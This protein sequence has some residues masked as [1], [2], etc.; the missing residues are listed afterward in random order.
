MT[1][2]NL[3]GPDAVLDFWRGLGPGG[4]FRKDDAVD[5]EISER[6][7]GLWQAARRGELAHWTRDAEGALA[8]ILV[9]DQFPRNMFRQSAR[10]FSTDAAAR[11]VAR[12]MLE[13]GHDRR[14]REDLRPFCYMPFMHS[15]AL[16]DQDLCVDLVRNRLD[17]PN[18]LHHAIQHRDVIARFGR[19][20]HRNA[21]LGRAPTEAETEFLASGG[22]V[23]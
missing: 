21:V 5:A 8:L 2:G 10:A 11:A 4:W 13:A 12:L 3:P 22:Y 7:E 15:E 16:E 9:L 20:P 19:F 23:P 14:I 17:N 18:T 1:A 6:F